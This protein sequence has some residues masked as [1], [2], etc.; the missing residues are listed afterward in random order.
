[1]SAA[2]AAVEQMDALAAEMDGSIRHGVLRGRCPE[3]LLTS[4]SLLGWVKAT[5]AETGHPLPP[6]IDQAIADIAPILRALRHAD[7]GLPRYHGGG[8]GA[9]GAG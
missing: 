9:A 8:R 5:A 2:R 4:L 1:M 7:G 3:A 6:E